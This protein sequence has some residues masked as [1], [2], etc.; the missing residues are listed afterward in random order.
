M[1]RFWIATIWLCSFVGMWMLTLLVVA[2]GTD[3]VKLPGK[4][5]DR[6]EDP[7]AFLPNYP[8][9]ALALQIYR[10]MNAASREY[11]PFIE[12]KHRP[13][14]T[15]TLNV[16]GRGLRTHVAGKENN[17][18]GAETIGFFGGSAMFGHG[19]SDDNT[20]PAQFDVLTTRFA[21]TNYAEAGWT[22][23][24]SLAH[25]IN[26]I[27][28]G[29]VPKI[30][31]FYDGFNDVRNLCN[32]MVTDSIAGTSMERRFRALMER[33]RGREGTY[34]VLI[35]PV[36]D[37]FTSA[38]TTIRDDY[39]CAEDPLVA[40]RVADAFVA[41]WSMAN[42]IAAANGARFYGFLQPSLFTG[43]P[44]ADYLP[45]DIDPDGVR[46]DLLKKEFDAVYP[47]IRQGL[48][49]TNLAWA[50]LTDA[51][52]V[53]EALFVDN[54]HV[55]VKGNAIIAGRVQARLAVQ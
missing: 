14:A 2:V 15:P 52:D 11:R 3:L 41:T 30:V 28:E 17:I 19:E 5:L 29:E 12:W 34:N 33:G 55:T 25:L 26:L 42:S 35:A 40:Q 44:K 27:A 38:K 6:K 49:K 9:H 53:D 18:Q 51:Y 31:V 20:I 47:L 10:D 32:R 46:N 37:L 8:D 39:V 7:R 1:R 23:R 4:F 22:S 21:V 48:A 54:S 16:D 43:S 50:D 24:Q 36:V 45:S 13:L